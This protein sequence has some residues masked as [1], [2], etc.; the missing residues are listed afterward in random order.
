MFYCFEFWAPSP[1]Y[2]LMFYAH[3]TSPFWDDD[4]VFGLTAFHER[5][6]DSSIDSKLRWIPWVLLYRRRDF[7]DDWRSAS[8]SV[9]NSILGQSLSAAWERKLRLIITVHILHRR[10]H[11][12]MRCKALELVFPPSR[13]VNITASPVFQPELRENP[14]A[15]TE[16]FLWRRMLW[17]QMRRLRGWLL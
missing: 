11:R 12:K 9:A 8:W 3:V 5:R 6:N 14:S 17:R 10:M 1:L 7:E 15:C 4:D 13:R 16:G 2:S